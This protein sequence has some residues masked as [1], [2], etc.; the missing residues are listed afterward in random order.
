[1]IT[2]DYEFQRHVGCALAFS[3]SRTW[4]KV[5]VLFGRIVVLASV[6]VV[7]GR[8]VEFATKFI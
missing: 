1:M 4:P 6:V 2:P 7:L 8:A 3:G 5:I